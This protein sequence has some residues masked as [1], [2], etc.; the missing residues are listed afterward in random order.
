MFDLQPLPEIRHAEACS[1]LSPGV[2]HGLTPAGTRVHGATGCDG[3]VSPTYRTCI[4]GLQP[5][6]QT[7]IMEA[8]ITS[9]G[10]CVKLSV[11]DNWITK[12]FQA[13]CFVAHVGGTFPDCFDVSGRSEVPFGFLFICAWM[14]I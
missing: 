5:R 4:V 2:Q 3:Q 8:M 12:L 13:Y 11:V 1:G 6:L 9:G 7:C 14:P 10:A